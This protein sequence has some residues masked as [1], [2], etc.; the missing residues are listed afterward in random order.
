MD[1][2][3]REE[4]G[5]RVFAADLDDGAEFL[6]R[7]DLER[8]GLDGAEEGENLAVVIGL[9]AVA[10]VIVSGGVF[11]VLPGENETL[12]GEV[13]GN[14]GIE[15]GDGLHGGR[16]GFLFVGEEPFLDVLALVR[17][18]RGD[19]DRVGHELH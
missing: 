17:D 13:R 1:A 3:A 19:G 16:A 6:E 10:A 5:Y 9:I 15:M 12:E 8:R 14:M 18:S 2:V 7:S 4:I 11:T